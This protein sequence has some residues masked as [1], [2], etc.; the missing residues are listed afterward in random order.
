MVLETHMNVCMIELTFSD[1][2]CLQN[3][4]NEP[5]I[6][7]FDFTEKFGRNFFL[8]FFHNE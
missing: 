8:N 6:L 2:F 4:E 5:K 1:I 7:F 3:G